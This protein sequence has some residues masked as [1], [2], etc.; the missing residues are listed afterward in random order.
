MRKTPKANDQY[1]F[2]T[3]GLNIQKGQTNAYV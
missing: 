2:K 3:N 1:K